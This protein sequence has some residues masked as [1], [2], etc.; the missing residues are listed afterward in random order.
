[1]KLGDF[2]RKHKELFWST[3]SYDT[4]DERVVVEAVLNYGDWETVQELFELLGIKRVAEVFRKWTAPELWR[5]NYHRE[6]K[7]YFNLYFNKYAS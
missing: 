5:T 3:R 1:M 2:A 4:L 7:H 6:I